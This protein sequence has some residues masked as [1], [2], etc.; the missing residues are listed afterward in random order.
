MDYSINK[1]WYKKWWAIILFIFLF[2]LAMIFLLVFIYIIRE[3]KNYKNPNLEN[4]NNLE[5]QVVYY[6][7]NQNQYSHPEGNNN[8]NFSIGTSTPK[9]TIVEFSSFSCPKSKNSFTKIRQLGLKYKNDVKIIFRHYPTDENSFLLSQVSYCSGEQGL[10][11]PMHDKLFQNQNNFYNEE[12]N[13]FAKQIG[14][15]MNLFSKCMEVNKYEDEIK[16]DMIDAERLDIKGT[17]TWFFNGRKVSGDISLEMMES[18]IVS[19]IK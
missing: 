11:W 5:N 7:N 9:L 1:K 15:D 16:N 17:P 8:L 2:L 13:N 10:F 4:I 19:L 6:I 12:I 18:I 3:I 14:L